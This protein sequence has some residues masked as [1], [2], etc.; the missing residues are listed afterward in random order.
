MALSI[1]RWKRDGVMVLLEF[2]S[3]TLLILI[4][5]IEFNKNIQIAIN[6]NSL[7]LYF[8]LYLNTLIGLI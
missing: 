6:S 7:Q 4:I 2:G 3:I 8:E 5:V 1:S